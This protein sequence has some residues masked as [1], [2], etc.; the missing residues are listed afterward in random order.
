MILQLIGEVT[1]LGVTLHF[2]PLIQAF[3]KAFAP[4]S[5]V[6]L[7]ITEKFKAE[8]SRPTEP[9]DPTAIVPEYEFDW[10][11]GGPAKYP[12]LCDLRQLEDAYSFHFH[13]A[14]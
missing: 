1:V 11:N 3:V 7:V 6:N 10:W 4:L 12:D 14:R 8:L 9:D 5:K 13:K 2:H